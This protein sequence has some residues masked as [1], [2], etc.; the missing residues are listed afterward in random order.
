MKPSSMKLDL[1]KFDPARIKED[2]VVLF[3]GKRNTGKSV[4]LK[5]ILSYHPS[6]P[7]GVAISPTEQANKYFEK[8][9]PKM[10]IHD[11]YEAEIIDKFMSRQMKVNNKVNADLERYGTTS[12]D[13]R[14]FLILDDCLYSAKDW[15][16]DKNIRSCFMNGRHYK[17]FFLMTMQYP[18]GIPPVLR[19]NIDYIFLFREPIM[20]NKQRLY[21]HYAGMFP[22]FDIFRQ[23]FDQCTENYECL[24]IDNK[25]QSNK[26]ED[27]VFWYKASMKDFKMC[28]SELWDMQAM[29]DEKK[30]MM[31]EELENDKDVDFDPN[32]IMKQRCR[33]NVNKRY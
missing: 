15:V 14:A 23:T 4:C 13:P 6:I 17:I 32:I 19:T 21:K 9:I 3:I 5:D 11:E 25:V 26:L 27:Q 18:L 31:N 1:K 20:E 28:D 22:T 7:I 12:V 2:S 29:H 24:V 33:I 16:S 10:L 8:F 30:T